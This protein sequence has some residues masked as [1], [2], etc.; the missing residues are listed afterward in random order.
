MWLPNAPGILLGGFQLSLT[1]IYPAKSTEE[2]LKSLEEGQS[3]LIRGNSF[4]NFDKV[5][6]NETDADNE[7]MATES[8]E[9]G[10]VNL[11]DVGLTPR[12]TGSHFAATTV[13]SFMG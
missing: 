3:K 10:V 2:T 8:S 6:Q 5:S 4:N 13:H 1:F 9:K 7:R 11:A 12:P